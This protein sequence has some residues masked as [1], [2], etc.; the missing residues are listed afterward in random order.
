MLVDAGGLILN[1]LLSP[2]SAHDS[3]LFEIKVR[4]ARR[5]IQ[6]RNHLDRDRRGAERRI[7]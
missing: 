3:M 2:A 1:A 7:S 6:S 5:G 4:S